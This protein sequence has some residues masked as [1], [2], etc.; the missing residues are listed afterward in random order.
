MKHPFI[1]YYDFES[2]LSEVVDDK[3]GRYQHHIPFNCGMKLVSQYPHLI[4]SQYKSFHGSDCVE[5]FLT[6][7]F[8][9]QN[10]ILKIVGMNVEAKR[11][12]EDMKQYEQDN[13]CNLCGKD[14]EP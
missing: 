12:K 10:K 4:Q 1:V 9:L 3:K 13:I 6:E 2:I 14:I 7:L 5:Q 8:E 11:T